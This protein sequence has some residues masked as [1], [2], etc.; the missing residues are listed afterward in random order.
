MSYNFIDELIDRVSRHLEELR[1]L[2]PEEIKLLIQELKKEKEVWNSLASGNRDY[3]ERTLE[4]PTDKALLGAIPHLAKSLPHRLG[5]IGSIAEKEDKIGD[6]AFDDVISGKRKLSELTPEELVKFLRDFL[7]SNKVSRFLHENVIKNHK[8]TV[9]AWL[10][11]YD[12]RS[13]NKGSAEAAAYIESKREKI[14]NLFVKSI[15]PNMMGAI[16]R[17]TA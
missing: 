17:G 7:N 3:F 8:R 9:I 2:K 10:G 14:M 6:P 5:F 4:M 12:R 16:A 1:G 15:L 11:A 13:A